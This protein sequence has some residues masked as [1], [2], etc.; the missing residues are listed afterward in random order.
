MTARATRADI[1]IL[2]GALS[3][4]A[5]A[6]HVLQMDFAGR[7]ILIERDPGWSQASTALSAGGYRTQFSGRVNVALSM[8]NHA[9]L[10]EGTALFGPHFDAGMRE[11]GYLLLASPQ[12]L[13]QLTANHHVQRAAGADT[14]VLDPFQLKERFNWL[15]TIGLGGAGFGLSGEGWFDPMTLLGALRARLRS[16]ER[17]ELV[18]GD[19]APLCSVDGQIPAVTLSSGRTIKAG[20]IVNA[21]GAAT[22]ALTARLA[23]PMP[24]EPRKRTVFH[25]RAPDHFVDMPLVVEPGGVYVRPEGDGYICGMSP[26]AHEDGAADPG[27][28]EPDWAL[29]E[30]R[31]W[32]VLAARIPAFERLRLI[33]AWAGH[34]DYNALDQNALIG[35]DPMV[36]NLF[37]ITGFSGHGVQQAFAA[38]EWLA[39]GILGCDAPNGAVDCQALS[40]ARVAEDRPFR[41]LGVI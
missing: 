33:S 12:G 8:R 5:T 4:M 26:S 18:T 20:L 25:F 15:E 23:C 24:V 40:P 38:G 6:W 30:D 22:G 19:I 29:F 41:E 37:H 16:D 31:I 27:D 11:N 14:V 28:F 13:D 36:P 35:R 10:R 34:Y 3:A 21:T 17:V 1:V 2:G 7:I 32:P 9:L 39:A